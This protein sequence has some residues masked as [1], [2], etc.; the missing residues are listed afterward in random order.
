MDDNTFNPIEA[1]WEYT[2]LFTNSEEDKID[3]NKLV[4]VK[5]DNTSISRSKYLLEEVPCANYLGVDMYFVPVDGE[6]IFDPLF[7]RNGYV[8]GRI[9]AVHLD[10]DPEG[11]YDRETRS[12][13]T[14][15]RSQI[16]IPCVTD[17][18]YSD[19]KDAYITW[20]STLVKIESMILSDPKDIGYDQY[21]EFYKFINRIFPIETYKK[22]IEPNL[23]PRKLLPVIGSQVTDELSKCRKKIENAET[24]LAVLKEKEKQVSHELTELQGIMVNHPF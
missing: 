16:I 11:I 15:R 10:Q 7:Y 24:E 4:V 6:R 2:P 9:A 1:T 19:G 13:N 23:K 20:Y 22:E 3:L 5:W 18:I 17:Q 12:G 8:I 14:L 21:M